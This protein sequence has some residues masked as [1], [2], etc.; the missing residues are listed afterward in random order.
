MNLGKLI[1]NAT[2]KFRK[3]AFASALAWMLACAPQAV[4]A[5]T[6]SQAQKPKPGSNAAAGSATSAARQGGEKSSGA[7]GPHEGIKVH[8]HWSIDIRNPDGTLVKHNEFENALQDDGKSFLA[9]TLARSSP[10]GTWDVQLIAGAAIAAGCVNGQQLSQA[11]A[12]VIGEAGSANAST[13]LTVGTGNLPLQPGQRRAVQT[14]VLTGTTQAVSTSGF[15]ITGVLTTTTGFI[16]SQA[17]LPTPIT[18]SPGQIIQVTVTFS[19]S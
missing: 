17:T 14:T 4:Q 7:G 13:N 19:F 12:C 3:S 1:R 2:R 10:V 18:V 5:Q 9:R 11:V 6:R 16:F 8:G 15:T